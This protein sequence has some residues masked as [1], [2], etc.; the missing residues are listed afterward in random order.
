MAGALLSAHLRQHRCGRFD[1]CACAL[2]D[3]WSV[4]GGAAVSV[5]PTSDVFATLG[6]TETEFARLCARLRD[7]FPDVDCATVKDPV[8]PNNLFR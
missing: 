7:A 6:L 4:V 8:T 3:V 2:S 1:V 5:E